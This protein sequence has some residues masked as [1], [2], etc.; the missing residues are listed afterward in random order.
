MTNSSYPFTLSVRDGRG[1]VL[2][3]DFTERYFI[4]PLWLAA[5]MTLCAANGQYK[6][7]KYESRRAATKATF[8]TAANYYLQFVVLVFTSS[9]EN[10]GQID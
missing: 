9:K 10:S 2:S 6:G 7:S 3:K 1:A 8:K 5:A 4:I